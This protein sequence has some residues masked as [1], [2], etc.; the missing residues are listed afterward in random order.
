MQLEGFRSWLAAK[1]KQQGK[2]AA[3]QVAA[4]TSQEVKAQVE[5]LR[6]PFNKL[7]NRKKPPPPPAPAANTTAANTT[8]EAGELDPKNATVTEELLDQTPR[9][10]DGAAGS[11]P[12][13]GIAPMILVVV[14]AQLVTSCLLLDVC[15]KQEVYR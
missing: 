6:K 3:D 15:G 12:S 5:A 11:A 13:A 10:D 14:L 2:L 7:K 9:P 8:A 1:L 4:V